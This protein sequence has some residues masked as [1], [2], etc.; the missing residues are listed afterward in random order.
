MGNLASNK[1]YDWT[2]EDYAVSATMQA[3]FANFIKTGNPN[4]TGLPLWPATK[5][6][7][8][9]PVMRIDVKSAVEKDANE[10]RYRTLEKLADKK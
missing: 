4:S 7:K 5:T 9:V 2:K 3:Y 8:P 6:S 10:N 1:V